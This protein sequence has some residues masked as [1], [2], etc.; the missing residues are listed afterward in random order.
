MTDEISSTGI[1][2]VPPIGQHMLNYMIFKPRMGFLDSVLQTTQDSTRNDAIC[3]VY[4]QHSNC[5]VL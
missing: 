4:N 3:Y 2:L 5:G 1:K